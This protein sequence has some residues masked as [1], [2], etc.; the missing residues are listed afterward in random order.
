MSPVAAPAHMQTGAGTTVDEPMPLSLLLRTSTR[1]AHT[2]AE[3]MGFVE[4][5]MGG[6]LGVRAYADLAAQQHAVYTALEESDPF[7]AA[8]PAGDSM[9]VDGLA[10]VPAIEQDLTHLF[11]TD[12]REQIKILPATEVYAAHLREVTRTWVGGYVAHAYTRYLGDLSGGLAIKAMLK[13]H[14]D[15]P[16]AGLNFYTFASIP[17]PKVFKDEYRALMDALPFDE[18]E[19]QQ[20]ADEAGVAFDL[21]TAMFA[22]LGAIHLR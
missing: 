14:Y 6:H 20:V 2:R 3:T 17:K 10:R 5:L 4:S 7:I 21:N 11:G 1:A 13:R 22:E 18:D 19:R 9:V 16:D 12:W 8:Q 15:V